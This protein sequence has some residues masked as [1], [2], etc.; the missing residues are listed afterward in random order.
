MADLTL[1]DGRVITV[2]LHRVSVREYRALFADD[3]PQAEEDATL[4]KAAGLTVD[5]LLNLGQ[6]DY[7]RLAALFF[8]LAREPLADPN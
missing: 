2:D 6:P 3:Q 7:R 1:A 4:A 8:K 5:E